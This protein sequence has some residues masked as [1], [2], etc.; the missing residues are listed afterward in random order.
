VSQLRPIVW[1]EVTLCQTR[2]LIS[3]GKKNLGIGARVGICT[4]NCMRT[5]RHRG[6]AAMPP[7]VLNDFG[8]CYVVT[9]SEL[10]SRLTCND[11]KQNSADKFRPVLCHFRWNLT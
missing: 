6:G 9:T 5:N 11:E 8:F 2:T 4:A 7:A 10:N 1:C 3:T